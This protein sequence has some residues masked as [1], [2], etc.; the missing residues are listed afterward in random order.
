MKSKLIILI[1]S[2]FI[3]T[4]SVFA[5]PNKGVKTASGKDFPEQE[6]KVILYREKAF[7]GEFFFMDEATNFIPKRLVGNYYPNSISIPKGFVA[8]IYEFVTDNGIPYGKAVELMENCPDLSVFGMDQKVSGV[9][10]M[11]PIQ[12]RAG[13]VWVRGKWSG[14]GKTATFMPGHWERARATGNDD[15]SSDTK[16]IVLPV[17]PFPG[18]N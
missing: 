12:P 2:C 13:F 7:S 8:T 15:S 18:K 16:P 3:L 14:K 6:T 11:K 9:V 4:I 10:V 1:A 17:V 5:Q